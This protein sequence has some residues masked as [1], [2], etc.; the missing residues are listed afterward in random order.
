[1]RIIVAMTGA[2]GAVCGV[3]LPA[4]SHKLEA[5]TRQAEQRAGLSARACA[6]VAPPMSAFN[7]NPK[8]IDDLVDHAVGRILNRFASKWPTQAQQWPAPA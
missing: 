1:M 4:A 5:E 8:S 6:I 2:T 7:G 3:C